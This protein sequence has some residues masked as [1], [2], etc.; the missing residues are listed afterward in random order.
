MD[1]EREEIQKEIE[2]LEHRL[3]DLSDVAVTEEEEREL[4]E[5]RA[6]V[7]RL[8]QQ[9][10]PIITAIDR[11]KLA[12]HP[13]RPQTLDFVKLLFED[14]CEIHGDRRFADDPAIVCGMAKFHA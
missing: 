6:R 2:E 11:V 10:S 5:L 3:S 7:G 9:I 14:F 12:R 13:D 1:K 8:E 4:S